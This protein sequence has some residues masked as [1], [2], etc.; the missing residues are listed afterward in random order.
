MSNAPKAPSDVQPSVVGIAADA[1]ARFI[2]RKPATAVE[3]GSLEQKARAL[4]DALPELAPVVSTL[5]RLKDEAAIDELLR[6]YEHEIARH[7]EVGED[8][9]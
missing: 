4:R 9:K 3:I 7:Q 2:R 5:V 1:L 8:K 6:L